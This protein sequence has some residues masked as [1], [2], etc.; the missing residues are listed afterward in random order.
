MDVTWNLF[1]NWKHGFLNCVY[2]DETK[3]GLQEDGVIS[4]ER[5]G[6][7]VC[8]VTHFTDFS[9]ADKIVLGGLAWWRIIIIILIVAALIGAVLLWTKMNGKEITQDPSNYFKA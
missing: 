7:I 2:Y 3:E 8:K 6:Y 1:W 5:E 9:V 4:E